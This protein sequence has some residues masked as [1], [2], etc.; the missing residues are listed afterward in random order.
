MIPNARQAAMKANAS[1]DI[2]SPL[3]SSRFI[4]SA[5]GWVNPPPH[6]ANHGRPRGTLWRVEQGAIELFK[7]GLMYE[8]S[9]PRPCM[10]RGKTGPALDRANRRKL[11]SGVR[12]RPNRLGGLLSII[13]PAATIDASV[14]DRCE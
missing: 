13:A 3:P 1:V 4:A 10:N 12:H 2:R 5:V 14:R 11:N 7:G 8:Q 6:R 9:P